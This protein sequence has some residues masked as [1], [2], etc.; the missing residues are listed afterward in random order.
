MQIRQTIFFGV[1]PSLVWRSCPIPLFKTTSQMLQSS[2]S[3]LKYYN[4]GI[5]RRLANSPLMA[6]GLIVS[7]LKTIIIYQRACWL[8]YMNLCWWHLLHS[9]DIYVCNSL[10]SLVTALVLWAKRFIKW[11]FTIWNKF[12]PPT[13]HFRD[14]Y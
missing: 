13:Q 1:I 11:C 9:L 4:N 14:I 8:W 6:I 2:V 7:T 12:V 10:D 5:Y 3:H